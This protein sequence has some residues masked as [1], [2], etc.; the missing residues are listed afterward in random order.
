[1]KS[2]VFAF[3]IQGDMQG[4]NICFLFYSVNVYKFFRTFST[5]AGRVIQQH[6]HTEYFTDP[7][8]FATYIT[9]SNNTNAHILQ[10]QIFTFRQNH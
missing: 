8:N 3:H 5:F 6:F 10:L 1:M 7:G 4:N 2:G 9:H